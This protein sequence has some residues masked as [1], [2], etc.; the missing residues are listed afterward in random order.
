MKTTTC[1]LAARLLLT[2]AI[3]TAADATAQRQ[4]ESTPQPAYGYLYVSGI[5]GTSSNSTYRAWHDVD[6]YA[7][8]I[9]SDA[10]RLM[11]PDP[12]IRD[13]KGMTSF[14][15]L[16]VSASFGAMLP[17]L[18]VRCASGQAIPTVIL[19][20][21]DGSAKRRAVEIRLR[22]AVV[23]TVDSRSDGEGMGQVVD[24]DYEELR[25]EQF[26]VVTGRSSSVLAFRPTGTLRSAAAALNP[27]PMALQVVVRV[28]DIKDSTTAVDGYHFASSYSFSVRKYG[29]STRFSPMRIAGMKSLMPKFLA[30]AVA[31]I[32]R[33]VVEVRVYGADA[34]DVKTATPLLTI[35][36]TNATFAGVSN[37]VS[38]GEIQQEVEVAYEKVKFEAQQRDYRGV[39]RPIVG[40]WDILQNRQF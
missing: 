39:L 21:M 2:A 35:E 7:L 36:L 37:G 29:T 1:T 6:A 11:N 25:I 13:R 17:L 18:L 19:R 27:K 15:S 31:G 5:Q 26:D 22:N 34:L 23:R 28:P 38:N 20:M 24:F 3:L 16:G 40:G 14:S 12:R 9:Q 32:K 33:P 4:V 30:G 10:R 8:R